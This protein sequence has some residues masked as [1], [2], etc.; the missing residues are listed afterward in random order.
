MKHAVLS[1]RYNCSRY[2]SAQNS[3]ATLQ[4]IA[5][6]RSAL[7]QTDEATK[8]WLLL[9]DILPR[10]VDIARKFEPTVQFVPRYVLTEIVVIAKQ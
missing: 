4:L 8:E 9:K 6:V 2:T 3:D 1:P 5:L 10:F 7:P